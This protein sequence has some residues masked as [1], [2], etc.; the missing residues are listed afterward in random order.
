MAAQPTWPE[1]Q[2]R[3]RPGAQLLSACPSVGGGDQVGLGCTACG[4]LMPTPRDPEWAEGT[5]KAG[6][7]A[8]GSCGVEGLASLEKMAWHGRGMGRV[9]GP[10]SHACRHFLSPW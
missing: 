2:A 10:P 7:E 4:S 1:L 3:R 9:R 5:G 6:A 8:V